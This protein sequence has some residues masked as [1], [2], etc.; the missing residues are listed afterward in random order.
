MRIFVAHRVLLSLALAA[1]TSSA[2]QPTEYQIPPT[3]RLTDV[4]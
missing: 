3:V 2:G 4:R 1:V